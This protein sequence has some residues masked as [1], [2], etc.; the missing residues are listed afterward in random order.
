MFREFD[1]SGGDEVPDPYYGDADGF[2]EV[3]AICRSAADGLVTA[4]GERLRS[5]TAG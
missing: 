2:A 4:L 3:A 1:P 5:R